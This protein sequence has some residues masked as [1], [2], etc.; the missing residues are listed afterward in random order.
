MVILSLIAPDGDLAEYNNPQGVGNFGNAQVADPAPGQWTALI[1]SGRSGA[2]VPAQFQASTATWQRF[3][4]LSASSLTL[5]AG[6]SGSFTLTVATPSQPGDQAGSIMLHNSARARLR[7]GDLDPGHAALAGAVRSSTTFTGTL[8]GGNGRA[9]STGQ[10]AYYQVEVPAGHQR[11]ERQVN[12]ATPATRCSPSWSTRPA[13][14]SRPRPTA[15]A[16]STNGGP[17]SCPRS[18]PSCTSTTRRAGGGR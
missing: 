3:G 12:T 14:P 16:T 4:T 7:R 8:T 13:R 18:A 15:L 11:A 5:A 2:A 10:T 9:P 1:S 17:G 6:A